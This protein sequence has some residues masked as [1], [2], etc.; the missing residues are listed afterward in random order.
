M[1]VKTRVTD[2]TEA[3]KEYF[4]E[5]YHWT[6]EDKIFKGYRSMYASVSGS[7]FWNLWRTDKDTIKNGGFWIRKVAGYWQL[8]HKRSIPKYHTPL[9]ALKKISKGVNDKLFDFQRPHVKNLAN[10]LSKE[11]AYIDGSDPGVGKTIVSL[12]LAKELKLSPFIICR[13]SAKAVWNFWAAYLGVTLIDA[14]HYQELKTGKMK[15]LKKVID[16]DRYG[17]KKYNYEWQ[18]DSKKTLIISD[19]CHCARNIDTF[20]SEMVLSAKNQGYYIGLLSATLIESPMQFGVFGYVTNLIRTYYGPG[21]NN[22]AADYGCYEE[23]IWLKD[24]YG[25]AVEK[26]IWKYDQEDQDALLR[27]HKLIYKSCG[28]RITV[29]E[30]G[31][32]FPEQQLSAVPYSM[33][34]SSKI[35]KIYDDLE[36]DIYQLGK[37]LANSQELLPMISFARQK[38][39]LLKVPTII[40]LVEDFLETG[41]SIAIFV[42]FKK[43][44]FHLAERMDVECLVHGDLVS[45]KGDAA[46][47]KAIDDFQSD[48]KRIILLTGGSGG[49][50]ISLHDLSG[51]FPRVS[52]ISPPWSGT[53]LVQIFGRIRRAGGKSKVLQR[54]IFA[55]ETIE[56][57]VA[58]IVMKK[59]NQIDAIN[60]GDLAGKF[61]KFI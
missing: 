21:F 19:E 46:R 59:V 2:E 15:Y 40:E 50:S 51:N 31:N 49:E 8:Y 41:K 35:S 43:T 4:L 32:K 10:I 28:S 38:V 13:K 39:E 36:K 47:Q 11:G 61:A 12:A 5:E 14:V 56:V 1:A 17:K 57:D 3:L 22:W 37:K 24:K 34:N 20:N 9:K 48:K 53:E 25:E 45:K 6:P 54:L 26:K 23:S 60:D 44:L 27:L 33:E 30:L 42:N 52:L 58:D 7:S 29:K 18:L 55:A 16:P